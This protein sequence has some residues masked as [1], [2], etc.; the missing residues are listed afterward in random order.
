MRIGIDISQIVHEGTGVGTYVR[1]IVRE[2]LLIDQ[3]NVYVLF[4]ASLRKLSRFTKFY[5]EVRVINPRVRLVTAPIPPTILEFVWNR[6][7][8]MPVEWL[9]GQV[10]VFWSSDWAHPPL[11]GAKGVTTIHDV[12]FLRYPETFAKTI[13]DVQKRRLA[14]V[15]RECKAVFCDSEA[16]KRDV[17]QLLGFE[18][19][20]L[21]VVYPGFQ[22]H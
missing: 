19:T 7:H 5:N 2:L 3:K 10:D 11:R 13:L 6:L 4:G 18:N 22:E 17:V 20:K 15:K 21:H 16:T 14:R 9:I 12:S 1:S 8:V